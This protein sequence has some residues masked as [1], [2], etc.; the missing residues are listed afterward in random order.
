MACGG[1]ATTR[2]IVD[3]FY[4]AFLAGDPEGMLDLMSPSVRVRFLGQ[5]D[6]KGIE[7]ARKFFAFSGGLLS[8][9]EFQIE[10]RI[11]DGQWAVVLWTETG[12]V[13]SSGEPWENHGVDVIRVH[14]GEVTI[15]H[16]NNDVRL[17][18]AHF[19]RFDPQS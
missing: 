12:S 7:E 14:D 1:V 15:V 3:R 19:P 11:F 2:E 10:E 6:L 18:R 5:A 17:V 4:S 8:N 13:T 9:L 16:E